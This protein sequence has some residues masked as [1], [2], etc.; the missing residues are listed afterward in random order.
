MKSAVIVFPGSN[1]DRDTKVAIE[2]MGGTV[3]YVWHKE[4]SLDGFDLVVLPGGFSYGDMEG[5]G[6]LAANS[7]IMPEVARHADR[8]GKTLGICNGFQI[9]VAAGLLPGK[10]ELNKSAKF[11]CKDVGVHVINNHSIF[12]NQYFY[13][14]KATMPIAHH[15]G[16]YV[17]G[18]DD[19]KTLS[20]KG[21]IVFT[22][23]DNPN[24]SD[25][26]IAGVLNWQGNVLGMM[27]HPERAYENESGCLGGQKLFESLMS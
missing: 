22:Y 7:T 5:P 16:K 17:I 19:Y 6:Y 13:Y 27:P 25:M 24:G 14:E 20:E 4:S 2:K 10:L 21:Q 11:I 15:S 9:L 26:N 23:A 18:V 1:C 8:G 12:T 3:E